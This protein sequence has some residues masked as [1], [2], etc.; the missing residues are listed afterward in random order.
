MNISYGDYTH[1]AGEVELL[2]DRQ[3]L[4]TDG[5]TPYAT[6]WRIDLVGLLLGEST[7]DLDRKVRALE[8]AYARRGVDFVVRPDRGGP[9]FLSVRDRDTAGGI[10]VVKPPSFPTNRRAVYSTHVPYTIALE[11]E[12]PLS[13]VPTGGGLRRFTERIQRRGG[14]GAPGYLETLNTPPIPYRGKLATVFETLQVGEA[15]GLYA[16]PDFPPPIWPAALIEAPETS[17]TSP[18][19]QGSGFVDFAITWQYRFESV[20]PLYGRPTRWGG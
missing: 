14:G 8:A 6:K 2:V 18:R 11:A 7:L 5:Q 1:Q 3:T 19:R 20:V 9:L 17:V 4:F 12:V 16:L 15:V 10:M 13:D